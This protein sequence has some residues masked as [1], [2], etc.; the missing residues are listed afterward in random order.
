MVR[1]LSYYTVCA[2]IHSEWWSIS[3]CLSLELYIMVCSTLMYT[4]KILLARVFLASNNL[5]QHTV[6]ILLMLLS[7]TWCLRW[8]K[9]YMIA[10]LPWWV[11]WYSPTRGGA[12]T[13]G[14]LR[15]SRDTGM[16]F[17]INPKLQLVLY[18][19]KA[20]S[21]LLS[22]T[23]YPLSPSNERHT[24]IVWRLQKNYAWS[25]SPIKRNCYKSGDSDTMYIQT[26]L[27][28]M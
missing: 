18:T 13:M 17:K 23:T 16:C 22:I 4:S 10:F 14:Q 11:Y 27:L 21:Q 7:T 15:K 24:C 20:H 3:L 28:T 9:V 19:M 12:G 1:N 25:D 6:I 5:F 8:L 2:S 26:V